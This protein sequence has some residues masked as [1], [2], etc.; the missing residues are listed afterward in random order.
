MLNNIEA[1]LSP[2]LN[3]LKM[4][5]ITT[6][7][8]ISM[9]QIVIGLGDFFYSIMLIFIG[10]SLFCANLNEFTYKVTMIFTIDVPCHNALTPAFKSRL[11]NASHTQPR[12]WSRTRLLSHD[13]LYITPRI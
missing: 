3:S 4:F 7:I 5:F 12:G 2:P 11:I 6:T 10:A 9:I 1:G 8:V 13:K